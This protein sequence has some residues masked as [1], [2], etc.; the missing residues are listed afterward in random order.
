MVPPGQLA[1]SAERLCRTLVDTDARL[2]NIEDRLRRLED[3]SSERRSTDIAPST[4]LW[5]TTAEVAALTQWSIHTVRQKIRNKELTAS[6]S[7]RG[8]GGRW[9]VLRSEVDELMR[10]G[11]VK[12]RK[13]RHL[14]PA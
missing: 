14:R 4:S 3:D 12:T 11:E 5:L 8:G 13:Q 9:R 7:G 10:R 1:D 2:A 6:K